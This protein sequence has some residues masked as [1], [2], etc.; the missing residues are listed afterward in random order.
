MA[1]NFQVQRFGQVAAIAT[2]LVGMAACGTSTTTTTSTTS[3]STSGTTESPAGGAAPA[4][5]PS[6]K[7][8]I[9]GDGSSTVF[10][11]SEAMAEEFQ[12][13]NPN[14]KVV[15]GTSGT[16]GGFKKFCSGETAFSNASRPI[17]DKEAA[18]CKEK[19]IEY[20]E[21]PVAFD[22]ITVVA[23][24]QNNWA[25]CLKTDELKTM[26]QSAAQKKVTKWNQV[27]S[28]F[29]DKDLALFGPGTDSGTF[30]YFTDAI[31]GKEGDS[32]GDFTASE[33]DNVLV[34]GVTGSDG[35][36]GYFGL[37][38]YEENKDKLTAVEVDGGKGCVAPS[39]ETVLNGTY[40]P[41]S[42]P[43]FVYFS[44]KEA[45]RPEVKAFVEFYLNAANKGF[46]TESGYVALQDE[47]YQAGLKR[48]Q[49]GKVGSV[50]EGGTTVGVDLKELLEK[51]TAK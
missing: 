11:I 13:A 32:R 2:L 22:A 35:A 48:F 27:R 7:G 18:A 24:K 3:G 43:L 23:N 34:Q 1:F 50:F 44:K 39:T 37:A 40:Q 20:I 5:D 41:L 51:E 31:N 49:E 28:D 38:Y 26:W 10:P 6:L 29:P 46:I 33:D 45:E 19:G 4:G 17:K 36:L 16:G 15:V 8:Q 25:K 14:V 9:D 47:L 42:R 30:D 12:K 21:I